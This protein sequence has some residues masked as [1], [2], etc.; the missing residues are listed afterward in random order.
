MHVNVFIVSNAK[1]FN[2]FNNLPKQRSERYSVVEV[3]EIPRSIA[4]NSFVS[5]SDGS[6]GP[7]ISRSAKQN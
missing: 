4:A 6:L 5:L 2:L 1:S 7:A 3:E